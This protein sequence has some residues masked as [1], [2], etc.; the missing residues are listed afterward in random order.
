MSEGAVEGQGTETPVAGSEQVEQ[1]GTG[2]NPA[3]NDLLSIVPSQLH[4]Q[5]TPHL[6]KWDQNFQTKLN[7][8]HSQ[9]AGYKPYLENQV[10]PDRINYALQMLEAIDQRP[11]DVINALNQYV[12]QAG[13][14][15]EEVAEQGQVD[16]NEE[17]SGDFTQH[18]EFQKM[19]QM[20]NT[21][22]EFLVQ[23][24]QT[25][26]DSQYDQELS[27]E[28]EQLK[29]THGEFDEDWV[30]TK[31]LQAANAGQ[32]V[33]SLEPYVQQY[34]QFEQGLIANSR[35]PGP[36]ILSPGGVAPD[37]QVDPKT[38]DDKGRRTLVAQMLES[39]ARESQ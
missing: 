10:E 11:M 29:E 38:L 1:S 6:K 12:D 28:L 19:Q 22:V 33:G 5:V 36:R 26:Q 17:P 35:R 34:R 20:V 2:I 18:P 27:S 15:P 31:A 4:S 8:V 23:Q 16:E 14:R 24:Q 32:E 3:W 39:A 9:Y 7:E 37:N 13:L 21:M 30:L 25:Q